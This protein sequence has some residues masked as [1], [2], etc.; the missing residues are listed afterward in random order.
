M[1]SQVQ[2]RIKDT[3]ANGIF[4]ILYKKEIQKT[5]N[6]NRKWIR[7]LQP[8]YSIQHKEVTR[9]YLDM[10][11]ER[12]LNRLYHNCKCAFAEQICKIEKGKTN[13]NN[14]D[15]ERKHIK[16]KVHIGIRAKR[17]EICRF[18]QNRARQIEQYD[19]SIIAY[20]HGYIKCD[21]IVDFPRGSE[22]RDMY[23]K[24]VRNYMPK[25]LI[26]IIN[27]L[28]KMVYP[29]FLR[30]YHQTNPKVIEFMD[31]LPDYDYDQPTQT[32]NIFDLYGHS[33]G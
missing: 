19:K 4:N 18:I 22:Y 6:I 25:R 1:I 23:Y 27:I 5:N 29:E 2:L 13:E 32:D 10:Y 8:S 16:T 33:L 31:G 24:Y 11:G 7:H 3:I 12:E 20:Y 14:G 30:R 15:K 21:K 17:K 26:N 28:V 9:W